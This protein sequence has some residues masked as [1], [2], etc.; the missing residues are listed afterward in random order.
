MHPKDVIWFNAVD[1][2]LSLVSDAAYLVLPDV[3]SCCA[4]SHHQPVY[5][6]LK[7]IHGGLASASEADTAEIFVGAQEVIH[8]IKT[9]VELGNPQPALWNWDTLN[10]LLGPH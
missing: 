2:M 5:V 10:L 4:A 8:M 7:T 6:L 1:I 9:L 3:R